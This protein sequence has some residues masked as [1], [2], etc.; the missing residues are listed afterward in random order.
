M[1]M[2]RWKKESG[3]LLCV[4]GNYYVRMYVRTYT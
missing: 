3:L 1:T 4:Y 2:N